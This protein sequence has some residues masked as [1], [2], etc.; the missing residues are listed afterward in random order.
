MPPENS[1]REQTSRKQ[2]H[3][4]ELHGYHDNKIQAENKQKEQKPT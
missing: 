1:S 2:E 4:Q 3:F